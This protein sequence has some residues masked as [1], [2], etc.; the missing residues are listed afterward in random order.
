MKNILFLVPHLSTGGMPQFLL[1]RVESIINFSNINV[2]VI[3]INNISDT[4]TVQ[5]NKLKE[6]LGENLISCGDIDISNKYIKLYNLLNDKN[7]DII[8]IE[9]N[10]EC[11]NG[12]DQNFINTIYDDDRKWRVV[13]TCHNSWFNISNKK[14]FPD[15]YSHCTY[16]QIEKFNSNISINSLVEY[17]I[18]KKEKDSEIEN[19]YDSNKINVLSVGLWSK[20]KNHKNTIE[21]A[22]NIKNDNIVFNIVGNYAD[23]FKDYWEEIFKYIPNN[24]K[25]WGEQSDLDKFYKN[26]DIFLFNSLD[27]CNPVSIK[28]A[29]SYNIPLLIRNLPIYNN[30]YDNISNFLNDDINHNIIQLNNLID[31]IKDGFTYEYKYDTQ[32][33]FY[34]KNID[35]YNRCLYKKNQ[36]INIDISFIDGVKCTI[37]GYSKYKYI[38]KFINNDT[39]DIIYETILESNQWASPNIKYF[40]NWKVEVTSDNPNFKT[41][42]KC[43]DL[44]NKNVHIMF[45]SSSLGDTISW[46]PYIKLFQEKHKCKVY[47]NIFNE[48][49]FQS[50]DFIKINSEEIDIDTIYASYKIGC[51]NNINLNPNPWNE[52]PLGKVCSDILGLYY[53]EI[54]PILSESILNIEPFK[55]GSKYVTISTNSTAKMKLWNNENGWQE[56]VDYLNNKGYVVINISNDIN[57]LKNTIYLKDDSIIDIIKYIKGSSFFIGLSS[58]LSWLSWCLDKKVFMINGFIEDYS[59]FTE[60][61]YKIKNKSVCNSCWNKVVFDKNYNTCV[62]KEIESERFQCSKS[63]TSKMVI[64]TIEKNI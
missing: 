11:I 51:Y 63:I 25:I 38:A 60:N 54:K 30:R 34:K 50:S 16:D 47:V 19:P 22:R 31:K 29:I 4:Y 37:K 46:F 40:I 6:I 13:E 14:Y 17:P 61:C 2:Y 8:H 64:D 48:Y 62:F 45:D 49:L 52:I 56:L 5:R 58:G 21:I 36:N 57:R 59:D 44:Y 39:N 10:I 26:A 42:T 24:V 53:K 28:E 15:G 3:E 1:Q 18:Y 55:I 43:I 7:I 27:E 32:Y 23:N 41:F 33:S 12:I 20:N 9:D 35:I